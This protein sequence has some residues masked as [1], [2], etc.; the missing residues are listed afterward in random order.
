MVKQELQTEIDQNYAFFKQKLPDLMK[1]HRGR[2]ALLHG[3]AVV[4]MYDTLRNA[5]TT[6]EKLLPD[7]LFSV[8]Q[9][10]DVAIDLGFFSLCQ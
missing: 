10:T 2:Y 8:Q 4:G 5:Q 1:D 7:G 9:V 6:G 3:K